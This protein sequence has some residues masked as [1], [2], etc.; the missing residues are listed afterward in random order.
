MHIRL[1][2]LTVAAAFFPSTGSSQATASA[3]D[4]ARTAPAR[5]TVVPLG[6]RHERSAAELRPLAERGDARAALQL[7]RMYASGSGVP[8]SREEGLAVVRRAAEAASPDAQA[9][10][11]FRFLFRDDFPGYDEAEALRWFRVA[12]AR[13]STNGYFGLGMMYRDGRGVPPS[14]SLAVRWLAQAASGGTVA[15]GLV[16]A[17]IYDDPA[18]AFHD[19]ARSEQYYTAAFAYGGSRLLCAWADAY[20][21]G[22]DEL[23][24]VPRDPVRA[25]GI[26]RRAT[27]FAGTSA[28]AARSAAIAAGRQRSFKR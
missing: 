26:Y 2:A 11:G 4:F 12:A 15:A 24:P 6:E 27:A 9:W 17:T 19:D 3:D 7:G 25:E 22:A 18:S 13:G 10:I 28:C 8:Q 14:D 20:A 5:N 16:L 23:F 21:G 1:L